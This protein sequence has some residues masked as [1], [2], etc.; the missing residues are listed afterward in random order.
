[1]DARQ[2]HGSM[3]A[4]IPRQCTAT[5]KRSGARCRKPAMQGR[6]VCRAHGGATPRGVASPHFR[7]GRWSKDLP[8]QLA[9]R[10][11]QARQ[12]A[13]LLSLQDEIALVDT[14]IGD[15]LATPGDGGDGE[16]AWA[17]LARLIEQRRRLTESEVK[18][19]AAAG[20]MVALEQV[21]ALAGALA[22]SVTAH[23]TDPAVRDAIHR[24]LEQL[25][26]QGTAGGH[27]PP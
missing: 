9:E 20:Q 16:V 1:M 21:L 11:T 3:E 25:L 8:A 4:A 24:D 12:D 10:Y 7:H 23:V 17:E 2:P 6:T 15:L 22:A 26:A 5:S 19:R 14:R 13:E 27:E 18:H